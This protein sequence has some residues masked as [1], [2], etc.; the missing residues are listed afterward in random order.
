MKIWALGDLH[1]ALGDPSKDMAVFGAAWEGYIHKIQSAWDALVAPEDLVLLPGDISWAMRLEEALV[2]LKW[3]DE[4]P[5]TKVMI[6]GNHDYWWASLAKMQ[7]VAPPSIHFLHNTALSWH[8]VAIA[9]SRLW[10]CE[11]YGFAPYIDV[12][13]NKPLSEI[14]KATEEDKKI[15]LRE[16]GRLEMSLKAMDPK[17]AYRIVM[18]HYPP[19]GADLRDSTVSRLLEKYDVQVCVFGHLHS[20]HSAIQGTLFG[21]KNGIR[22]LLTASDYVY[23]RPVEILSIRDHG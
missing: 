14:T 3:I 4:R 13:G 19:I 9:G 20:L 17:A 10:D 22:Y 18:T 21:E 15:F 23:H 16:L 8:N 6:R 5:G 11:E 7:A 12:Q 1:L 2:D